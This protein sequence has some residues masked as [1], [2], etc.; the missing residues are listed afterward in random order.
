M[1]GKLDRLQSRVGSVM[2]LARLRGVSLA[3]ALAALV[4]GGAFI[5]ASVFDVAFRLEP[6]TR[7]LLLAGS[8]VLAIWAALRARRGSLADGGAAAREVERSFPEIESSLSTAIEFGSDPEKTE[9]YSSREIVDGLVE[10]TEARTEPLPFRHA[11]NWRA[12]GRAGAGLAAVAVAVL[13]YAL[14][15]PHMAAS[16]AATD[17]GRPTSRGVTIRPESSVSACLNT[18]HVS[19]RNSPHCCRVMS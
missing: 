19:M 8:V 6:F 16:T 17:R 1:S 9:A 12:V 7:A 15:L 10:T 11:V 13:L 4:M 14:L 3:A 18:C 2:R 5:A